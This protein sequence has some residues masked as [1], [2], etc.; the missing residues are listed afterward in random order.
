MSIVCLMITTNRPDRY[1]RT[2]DAMD[3]VNKCGSHLSKKILS[4]D[5]LPEHEDVIPGYEES[6]RYAAEKWGWKVVT[7]QCTGQRAMVNNIWRGLS[8]ISGGGDYIF[9]CEDHVRIQKI[10]TESDL[11]YLRRRTSV[12]WICYNTHVHQENLLD[13]PGFVELPGREG[14]LD[15]VNDPTHW[16]RTESGDFLVKD[17]QIQDEYFLNFPA[18]ITHVNTF[19]S[20]LLYACANY[21]G[22]GIEIGFTKAWSDTKKSQLWRPAIYAQPGTMDKLPLPDFHALH[23]RACMRFRNNDFSMLHPSIVPHQEIPSDEKQ[24]RSFF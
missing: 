2:L 8:E 19:R 7:G 14:R 16:I 15:F 12:E 6:L 18:A 23:M 5:L 17:T 3:S 9:Y 1:E 22:I 21:H 11:E 4:I 20:L 13:V 10:P 24:Q